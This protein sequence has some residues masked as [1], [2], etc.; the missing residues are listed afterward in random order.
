MKIDLAMKKALPSQHVFQDASDRRAKDGESKLAMSERMVGVERLVGGGVARPQPLAAAGAADRHPLRRRPAHRL[1]LAP[2]CRSQQRL[3]R[4]LLL[5]CPPGTQGRFGGHAAFSASA[6]DLA[7]ARPTAGGHRRLPH[8]AV[9]TEGRRGRHPSQSHTRPCRPEVPVW[10]HLGHPVV[11]VAASVVGR[12]GL[13]VAGHAV[14]PSKDHFHHPQE[15]PLA[16]S[17]QTPTG[18]PLGQVDGSDW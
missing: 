1:Q 12:A 5:P 7:F 6:A 18:G 4:V 16:V 17:D 10:T 8:Q 9:R 13:A 15:T 2:C 3:P 11:G 14:R